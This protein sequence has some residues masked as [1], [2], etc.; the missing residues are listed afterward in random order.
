MSTENK[1][2]RQKAKHVIDGV[3]YC[4]SDEHRTIGYLKNISLTG[5]SIRFKNEFP[6]SKHF[7]LCLPLSYTT[8]FS[9]LE[10]RAKMIWK[11]TSPD[12]EGFI[13][14]G[15]IFEKITRELQIKLSLVI[16]HM[17]TEEDQ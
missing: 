10:I 8:P 14:G 12:K 11:S 3:V 4:K 16:Q 6:V 7:L 9:D 15:V 17:A 13:T 1:K 2:K 5:A